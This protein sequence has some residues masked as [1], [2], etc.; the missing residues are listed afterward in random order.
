L[1]FGGEQAEEKKKSPRQLLTKRR[2]VGNL[3]E[4]RLTEV[5]RPEPPGAKV[6]G[7]RNK[8]T[9]NGKGKKRRPQYVSRS[10]VFGMKKTP[11][12][13]GSGFNKSFS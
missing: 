10:V 12:W 8:H 11:H 3:A 7:Y 2:E 9:V 4:F 13:V 1:Q 5:Q 6:K